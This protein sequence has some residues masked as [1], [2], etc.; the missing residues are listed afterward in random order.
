MKKILISNFP[1]GP[2]FNGG[3]M[4]VWGIIKY[5]LDNKTDFFLILTCSENQK[6]TKRFN[7]CIKILETY[8][9][10]YELFFLANKIQ[11]F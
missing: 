6:N 2:K 5:F 8:N 11:I 10:D 3:S 9:I 1:V 7:E 4:T